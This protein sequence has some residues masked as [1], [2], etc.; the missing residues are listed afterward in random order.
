M[1]TEQEVLKDLEDLEWDTSNGFPLKKTLV[2][3]EWY[4]TFYWNCYIYVNKDNKT[5]AAVKRSNY[6]TKEYHLSMHEHK[7]LNE[8]FSIWGWL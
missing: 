4:A 1:R 6:S 7:L 2:Q 8:L 5:Y 3:P